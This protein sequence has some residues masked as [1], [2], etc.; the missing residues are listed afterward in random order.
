MRPAP[1]RCTSSTA[2]AA[3]RPS[4]PRPPT[5]LHQTDAS[6]DFSVADYDH[7]GV[8]DLWAFAR[9]GT[10]S[11]TTEVHILDGA[12]GFQRFIAHAPTALQE[13]P[14][15]WSFMTG[16][17]NRDG[18]VDVIGVLYAGASKTTEVHVL[19]GATSWGTFLL[20]T[21]TALAPT[22]SSWDF[23]AADANRDGVV[24]VFA[25]DRV[26]PG[27]NRTVVH[28][29]DGANG[30]GRFVSQTAT[31]LGPTDG[32]WSFVPAD[33]SHDGAADLLAFHR[34]GETSVSILDGAQRRCRRRTRARRA[35][36]RPTR[37]R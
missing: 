4:S 13:S 27:T 36:A 6:W 21:P 20:H 22:D 25:I 24:D 19:D 16:D 33:F 35:A 5:A 31:V 8:L 9:A 12:S 26:D 7:D 29:L 18:A 3:T 17:V 1:P 2:R 28:V 32:A 15:G 11:H 14:E 34:A 10:G 30:F 37:S 23:G